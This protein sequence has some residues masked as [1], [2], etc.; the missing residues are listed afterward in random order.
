MWPGPVGGRLV[1]PVGPADPEG[2]RAATAAGDGRSPAPP[3]ADYAALA[4]RRRQVSDCYARVRSA[5]DPRVAWE[6]WRGELA[7]LR[8]P[9]GGS[10]AVL[11]AFAYDAGWRCLA[12][13][14]PSDP[15]FVSAGTESVLRIG[16]VTVDVPVGGP[17]DLEMYWVE[18]HPGGLLLPFAD[19]TNGRSTARRGRCLIDQSAGADLGEVG[20][21]WVLDFNFAYDAGPDVAAVMAIPR[22]A[23]PN[24]IP[25]E[26]AV[27]ERNR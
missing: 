7:L 18:G 22:L 10:A 25:V 2:G 16:S 12:T 8:S 14:T 20:G 21:R 11:P 5:A 23:T 9:V 6:L 1:S 24:R 27:G 17:V 19:P 13:F 3:V 15:M 4:A 26:V